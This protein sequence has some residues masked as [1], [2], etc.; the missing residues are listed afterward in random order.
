MAERCWH[1]EMAATG[2]CEK[3][4][5]EVTV[6]QR[7]RA[8]V[9]VGGGDRATGSYTIDGAES[10]TVREAIAHVLGVEVS[11]VQLLD[12]FPAASGWDRAV[13]LTFTL[14]GSRSPIR[15]KVT[16]YADT[17]RTPEYVELPQ[18]AESL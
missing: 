8:E 10:P 7:T 2:T 9:I 6:V 5:A 4:G 18:P 1:W 3:C 14:K 15:A 17:E 16:P 11:E 12:A 13:V